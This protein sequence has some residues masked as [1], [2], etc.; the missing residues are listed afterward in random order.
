MSC[1]A[2]N[3]A[4]EVRATVHLIMLVRQR[5]L[6]RLNLWHNGQNLICHIVHGSLHTSAILL[7]ESAQ[8]NFPCS[9]PCVIESGR[10]GLDL[11]KA[12]EV[13]PVPCCIDLRAENTVPDFR[14]SSVF[15]THESPEL[16]SGGFQ[17][18]Q[19]LNCRSNFDSLALGNVD[20]D[21]TCFSAI[22]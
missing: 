5:V 3:L 12:R 14:Q 8:S 18:M 6:H 7:C 20:L 10:I 17:D 4:L 11:S 15:V 22:A 1:S 21:V 13:L 2:H 16:G 19:T 9:A